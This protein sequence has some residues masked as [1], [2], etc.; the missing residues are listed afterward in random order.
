MNDKVTRFKVFSQTAPEEIFSLLPYDY[1]YLENVPKQVYWFE[2]DSNAILYPGEG[3]KGNIIFITDVEDGKTRPAICIKQNGV[4]QWVYFAKPKI[5]TARPV[6]Y[7]YKE[8]LQGIPHIYLVDNLLKTP[9]IYGWYDQA[10]G[11]PV[12]KKEIDTFFQPRIYMEIDRIVDT[13]Y[14]ELIMAELGLPKIYGQKDGLGRPI[15]IK[16]ADKLDTPFIVG[17]ADAPYYAI[18]GQAVLGYSRLG[19]TQVATPKAVLGAA[20]LGECILGSS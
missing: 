5:Q 20:R 1:N 3:Q 18:L 17:I 15:I 4:Y 16:I 9:T 10:L 19:G 12:I 14:I 8:T 13:P 7:P 11:T 6:I 2:R